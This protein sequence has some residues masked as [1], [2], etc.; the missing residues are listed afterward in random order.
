[1]KA[2]DQRPSTGAIERY[3]YFSCCLLAALGDRAAKGASP[4]ALA[5]K[6]PPV[7]LWQTSGVDSGCRWS[8]ADCH[9]DHGHKPLGDKPI[10]PASPWQNGFAERLIGSIRR[11]CLDHV[12]VLGEAH[13][14]R[15]LK[16]YARYYNPVS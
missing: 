1:L 2:L 15:I 16:S 11:E 10:A 6:R 7:R 4:A 9:G 14:R 3:F 8:R 12:I 5:R 13:L